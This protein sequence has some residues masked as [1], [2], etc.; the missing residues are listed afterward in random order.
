MGNK[1]KSWYQRCYTLL[2]HEI[3]CLD[4][5]TASRAYG[6]FLRV[7]R[8]VLIAGWGFF[9]KHHGQLRAAALTYTTMLVL[10]PLLAFMVAFLKG[11]G[12]QDQLEPFFLGQLPPDAAEAMRLAF[13]AVGNVD[14]RT[15]GVIGLVAL[16][17]TTILQISTIE[18]AL[19][20]IW[21][22]KAG[23]SLPRKMT[24]YV[25][26]LVIAPM[27]I[28]LV[29]AVNTTLR[30][31]T[32]VTMLL[33][34]RLI[35]EAMFGLFTIASYVALWLVFAFL[36]S[37]LPNTRVPAAT[38][39]LGGIV[40]GSLWHLA[41]WGYLTFQLGVGRYQAIYGALAQLPAFMVWIYL[42]WV[43]IL[44]GAEV[45]WAC[46]FASRPPQGIGAMPLSSYDRERLG[47]AL[48]FDVAE[49][50]TSSSRLWSATQFAQQYRL[51]LTQ[52]QELLAPLQAAGLL[53]STAATADHYVPGRELA[54][55]TPWHILRTLRHY[56]DRDGSPTM[57]SDLLAT[58]LLHQVE[59]TMEQRTSSQSVLQYL[60][61]AAMSSFRESH[62]KRSSS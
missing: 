60:D 34:Q 3:W 46:Q 33:Q 56:G 48:Y 23:R 32:L 11:F 24:D 42:S 28:V 62:P 40:G 35:G 15:L 29:T 45:T 38:A 36:Y 44:I 13:Q 25:S 20:A 39:L 2:W 16:L 61:N 12:V 52:V 17:V 54:T 5:T 14:A 26:I 43:A 7:V 59:E 10:V 1:L 51:S 21:D 27:T 18:Q 47:S 22:V 9:S 49:A 50:F 31:H 53:L 30:H 58:T 55:L 57:P 41:Q 37:F 8:V 4:E 19:N 6:W